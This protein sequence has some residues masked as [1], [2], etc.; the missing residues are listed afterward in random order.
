VAYVSHLCRSPA[1]ARRTILTGI[2]AINAAHVDTDLPLP[3][4]GAAS[5]QLG[6]VGAPIARRSAAPAIAQIAARRLAIESE[7]VG[8]AVLPLP[9]RDESPFH[10]GRI[11]LNPLTSTRIGSRVTGRLW[12]RV[13]LRADP[14]WALFARSKL[15]FFPSEARFFIPPRVRF[16]SREGG[17]RRSGRMSRMV[18]PERR[19]LLAGASPFF[20]PLA[21]Y[22]SP[23]SCARRRPGC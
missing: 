2:Q 21:R 3:A 10:L 14:G 8:G 9:E 12:R 18:R 7:R 4:A 5:K 19:E 11:L 17:L 23:D 1:V 20:D 6:F 13:T 16:S 22:F 15:P